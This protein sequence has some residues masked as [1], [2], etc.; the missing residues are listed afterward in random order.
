M[1]SVHGDLN[2]NDNMNNGSVQSAIKQLQYRSIDQEARS[3]RQNLLFYNIPEERGEDVKHTLSNLIESRLHIPG[4]VSIQRVHR[5]GAARQTQTK[6][7][8][9]IAYFGDYCDIELIMGAAKKLAG[10]KIGISRD[11]ADMD[12]LP[13]WND[14][15]RG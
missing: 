3:R 1:E 4:T 11:Y 9:I 7:R 8:P 2:S 13:D 14:V 5:L 12:E 6:P 15:L 10:T